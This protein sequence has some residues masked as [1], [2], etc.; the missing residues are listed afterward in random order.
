MRIGFSTTPRIS[1]SGFAVC[2]W[3]SALRSASFPVLCGF[4]LQLREFGGFEHLG[5][6]CYQIRCFE[7]LAQKMQHGPFEAVEFAHFLSYMP[8]HEEHLKPLFALLHLHPKPTAVA[9]RKCDI[10]EQ[11]SD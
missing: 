11:Q 9:A 6:P 7:W 10:G 1:T 2:S 3:R 4:S 5:H 8:G